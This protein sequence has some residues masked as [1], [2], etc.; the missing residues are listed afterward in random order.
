MTIDYNKHNYIKVGNY[1]NIFY[2]FP[3]DSAVDTSW[4][5]EIMP[6]IAPLYHKI[7]MAHPDWTI[8]L[9]GGVTDHG[10]HRKYNVSA[11][12]VICDDE[13][14]GS[15][16]ID[17]WKSGHPFTVS[18]DKIRNERLRGSGAWTTK[19]EKA[20]KLVEENFSAVPVA[21]KVY[22]AASKIS[23]LISGET[24]KKGRA[25]DDG[26]TKLHPALA[27]YIANNLAEISKAPEMAGVNMQ[28][29]VIPT[30]LEQKAVVDSFSSS[31]RNG[32]GYVVLTYKDKYLVQPNA[33]P[34]GD[35]HTL[36]ASELTPDMA[37]KIGLLKALDTNDEF[38]EGVGVRTDNNAY[39]IL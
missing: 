12:K 39:F 1:S 10:G 2:E 7:A 17:S 8:V 14:I 35:F 38:I 4:A 28:L 25:V 19:I 21:T 15:I 29:E 26:L 34:S 22:R 5:V 31:V 23:Q 18:C 13:I 24:Y 3:N 6:R 11:A 33:A 20:Y 30:L 37:S 36:T 27:A 32:H 16:G 9:T